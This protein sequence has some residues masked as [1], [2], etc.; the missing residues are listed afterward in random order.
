[1]CPRW[2]KL[3]FFR[4]MCLVNIPFS[5]SFLSERFKAELGKNHGSF[6]CLLSGHKKPL[7][8][9]IDR[10]IIDGGIL[11]LVFMITVL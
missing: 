2:T 8:M 7:Q 4:K 11:H 6:E 3:L 10:H 1:M 5:H 9:H